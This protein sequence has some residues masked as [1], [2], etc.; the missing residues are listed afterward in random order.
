MHAASAAEHARRGSAR[1]RLL[2]GRNCSINVSRTPLWSVPGLSRPSPVGQPSGPSPPVLPRQ[3]PGD[4]RGRATLLAQT[5]LRR[6]SCSRARANSPTRSGAP[7]MGDATRTDGSTVR[8][9]AGSSTPPLVR[10]SLTTRTSRPQGRAD[11]CYCRPSNSWRF[12]TESYTEQGQW[13]SSQMRV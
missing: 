2:A 1:R 13:G 5:E 6:L 12:A 10:L 3:T 9:P 8:N 4:P 7:Y 11:P